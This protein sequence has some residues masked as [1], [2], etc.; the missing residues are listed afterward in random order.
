MKLNF[1]ELDSFCDALTKKYKSRQVCIRMYHN[2]L[3]FCINIYGWKN[4][5]KKIKEKTGLEIK[6][7]NL[8][9]QY[10]R[11]LKKLALKADKK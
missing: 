6:Q 5:I 7:I 2:D 11:E 4:I 10:Y 1:D 9:N 3:T 8:Q